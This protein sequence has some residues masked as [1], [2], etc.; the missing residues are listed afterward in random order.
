MKDITAAGQATIEFTNAMDFPLNLVDLINDQQNGNHTEKIMEVRIVPGLDQT[1]ENT[2]FDWNISSI[3]T[4]SMT[5][6]IY[7][8]EPLLISQSGK[9]LFVVEI[10]Q[11]SLFQDKNGLILLEK[12]AIEEKVIPKQHVNAVAEK[13][14]DIT[15]QVVSYVGGVTLASNGILNWIFKCSLNFVWGMINSMQVVLHFP[16]TN[17]VYPANALV[18]Y[19]YFRVIGTFD[20]LPTDYLNPLVLSFSETEPICDQFEELDYGGTNFIS[21]LG[22]I[23]YAFPFTGLCL[24]L[25]ALLKLLSKRGYQRPLEWYLKLKTFLIKLILA[26]LYESYLELH[27]SS[28]ISVANLLFSSH[29]GDWIGA[30]TSI[31][32]A[33]VVNIFPFGL[34]CFLYCKKSQLEDE[35]FKARFGIVYEGLD[36]SR[37][38]FLV[39]PFLFLMRRM[40]FSLLVIFVHQSFL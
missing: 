19:T 7:F 6:A 14:I 34:M 3:D 12:D 16:L 40:I 13:L 10:I 31:L 32:V 24:I 23:Y 4:Y 35:E 22:S 9:D 25:L 26:I 11:R 27:L 30:S 8:S 39:Y 36:T 38:T 29:S 37:K 17:V 18:V 15:S 5:V 2:N 20:V 28:T 21:N 33:I 1:L